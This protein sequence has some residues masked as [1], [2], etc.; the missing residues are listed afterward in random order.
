MGFINMNTYYLKLILLLLFCNIYQVFSVNEVIFDSSSTNK[1]NK[2]LV[3]N[4]VEDQSLESD[5]KNYL[6]E[7]VLDYKI[8]ITTKPTQIKNQ[9]KYYSDLTIK[10]FKYFGLKDDYQ[11]KSIVSNYESLAKL[12]PE[13][14]LLLR[15]TRVVFMN[16]QKNLN[17]FFKQISPD[18]Y[19]QLR[20]LLFEANNFLPTNL[21]ISDEELSMIPDYPKRE[22]ENIAEK[23]V[24]SQGLKSGENKDL[25]SAVVQEEEEKKKKNDE[26]QEEIDRQNQA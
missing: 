11:Q 3:A 5:L 4:S 14:K 24:S 15:I 18:K 2:N 17:S 23:N 19:S 22:I 10:I 26:L 16:F 1:N 7:L 6:D 9:D 12:S 8:D 20:E 25:D 13:M 21:K